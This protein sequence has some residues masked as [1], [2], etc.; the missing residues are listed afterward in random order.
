[1]QSNKERKKDE[2]GSYLFK[3]LQ[4]LGG[5]GCGGSGGGRC[6]ALTRQILVCAKSKGEE[7]SQRNAERLNIEYWMYLILLQ[8][9]HELLLGGLLTTKRGWAT[10]ATRKKERERNKER[11]KEREKRNSF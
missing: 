1:M 2:K 5:C 6:P 3:L 10:P 11:K 4:I 7:I 8:I 9:C